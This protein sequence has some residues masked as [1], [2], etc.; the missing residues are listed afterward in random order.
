[1]TSSVEMFWRKLREVLKN[2]FNGVLEKLFLK[3]I[4]WNLFNRDVEETILTYI[5]WE[6][7]MTN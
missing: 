3:E 2:I 5:A 4:A 1:M 7:R 6:K